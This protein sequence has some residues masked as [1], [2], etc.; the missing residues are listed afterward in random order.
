LVIFIILA[1][2]ND[3]KSAHLNLFLCFYFKMG[4]NI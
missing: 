1:R 3:I 4:S 2:Q